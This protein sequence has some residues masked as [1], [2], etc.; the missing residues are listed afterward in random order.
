M[1]IGELQALLAPIGVERGD[2]KA[3]G[4]ADIGPLRRMGMPVFGLRQD[5]SEYFDY[6]HTADDTLDKVDRDDLNQNVAAYVTAAYVAANIERDFGRLPLDDS[7]TSC[8][9]EFD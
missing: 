3:G 5:G 1:I 6:H 4:G 9:V 7:K 2:N 8:A